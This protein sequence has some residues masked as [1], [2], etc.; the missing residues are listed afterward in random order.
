MVAAPYWK[1]GTGEHFSSAAEGVLQLSL[2][3][4]IRTLC[5]AGLLRPLKLDLPLYPLKGE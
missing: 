2:V 1:Q 5:K 4:V 3:L